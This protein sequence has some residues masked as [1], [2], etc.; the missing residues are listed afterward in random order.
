MPVVKLAVTEWQC[1]QSHSEQFLWRSHN[2]QS[3][4]FKNTPKHRQFLSPFYLKASCPLR[5]T[6]NHPK[7]RS[8]LKWAAGTSSGLF[9]PSSDPRDTSVFSLRQDNSCTK[10]RVLRTDLGSWCSDGWHMITRFP[11]TI[12]TA[13]TQRTTWE[14]PVTLCSVVFTSPVGFLPA[15][16]LAYTS[17]LGRKAQKQIPAPHRDSQPQSGDTTWPAMDEL[18]CIDTVAPCSFCRAD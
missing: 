12:T 1:R 15:T 6:Y 13:L 7:Y 11:S 16:S 9:D 5:S 14:H 3:K 18:H 2:T 4:I 10:Y 17:S 8:V